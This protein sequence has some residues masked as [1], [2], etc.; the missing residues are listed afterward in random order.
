M[1]IFDYNTIKDMLIKHPHLRNNDNALI[2]NI[3]WRQLMASEQTD[4]KVS[5]FLYL[6]S[7]GDTLAK[8][9]SITRARRKV[10]E[11]NPELRGNSYNKRQK[12][13]EKIQS[14]LGYNIQIS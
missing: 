11:E 4:I 6:F 10:Q 1:Q 2:S 8:P 7:H 12:E 3:W 5:D 14:E 9:E 13:Q